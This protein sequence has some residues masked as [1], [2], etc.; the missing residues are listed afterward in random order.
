MRAT[1]ISTNVLSDRLNRLLD[2]G[3]IGRSPYGSHPHRYEYRLTEKGEDAVPVLLAWG[4]RWTS[5]DDGPPTAVVHE[6]CGAPTT[7]VVRCANCGETLEAA[8]L[9]YR[10]GPGAR[11]GPGTAVLRERL[12][13][14]PG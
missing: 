8:D 5:D 4:D 13:E 9:R 2:H 7:P 14:R 12:A 1:G 3:V 10:N 6:P 11:P